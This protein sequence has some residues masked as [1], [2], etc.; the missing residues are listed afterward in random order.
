MVANIQAWLDQPAGNFGWGLIATNFEHVP[1]TAKRFD[2][3]ENVD[4]SL[5]PTL[6][7]AYTPPQTATVVI[8]ALKDNTLY[9][10]VSG[11]L[12]NGAGQHMFV[13]TTNSDLLR[14]AVI[15]FDVAAN[16]PA[17]STIQSVVLTL[18]MSQ[19]FGIAIDV[20]L[21]PAT[22]D[23]GEG[24]SVAQGEEDAGAPSSPGDAT[25]IHTFFDTQSWIFR[26]GISSAFPVLPRP[27]AMLASTLGRAKEWWPTCSNGSTN[28]PTTSGGV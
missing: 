25:W 10:D 1:M 26:V 9:E 6:F 22:Q 24:T 21:C 4:P 18:N 23:W 5:R 7:I 12:S 13:G 19:T 3:R 16:V 28:P 20:D 2:T 27:S 14:R 17:G 15:A 8:P 11:A